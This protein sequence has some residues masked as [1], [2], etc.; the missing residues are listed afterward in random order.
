MMKTGPMRENASK[1]ILLLAALTSLL[2]LPGCS[3]TQ[4]VD[5]ARQERFQT[6]LRQ[7]TKAIN[8][9]D[10]DNA[11]THL[12]KVNKNALNHSEKRKAQSLTKLVAGA[13]ALVDG[14]AKLARNEWSNIAD[15]RLAR[16]VR[17]RAK[18]IDVTVPLQPVQD[19]KEIN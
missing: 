16:Q 13:Q 4:K 6:A 7:C 19:R 1:L 11:Q 8:K 9:G 17:T 15:P 14:D 5:L 10:L 18:L 3:S 12:A 2:L